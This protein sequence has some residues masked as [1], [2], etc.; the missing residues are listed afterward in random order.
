MSRGR[1]EMSA[2]YASVAML[3][4]STNTEIRKLVNIYLV[5]YS[6]LE[7]DTALLAINT[8]KKDL[9]N[10][11]QLVRANAVR[12]MSSIRVPLISQLVSVSLKTAS[13]DSSP[14]VRK[15]AAHAIPKLYSLD[16]SQEP[17]ILEILATLL[18]DDAIMVLG[19]AIAAFNEVC[20]DNWDLIHRN[21]R[22]ICYLVGD[23]EEWGQVPALQMLTRY[24]RTQFLDPYAEFKR[25]QA[26]TKVEEDEEPDLMALSG[27]NETNLD[28]DHRLLLRSVLPLLQSRNPAVNLAVANLYHHLSP[29][30][31]QSKIAKSL[32]RSFRSSNEVKY[33]ILSG[34][35]T[36]VQTNPVSF[37][38]SYSYSQPGHVQPSP[39]RFLCRQH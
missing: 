37:L 34:I 35:L 13:T 24:A 8:L 15:T 38:Y 18:N 30:L 21:F 26:E 11:N 4:I 14:Y 2:C 19:S 27:P 6:E 20:P 31:E 9:A 17:Q 3:A 25:K 7:T 12:T 1:N 5:H 23:L 28:P 39:F 33:V 10:P 16:P 32:I 36:F 29:K 22:K